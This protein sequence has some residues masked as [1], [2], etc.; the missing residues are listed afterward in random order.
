MRDLL[1]SPA[2]PARYH[3]L[4]RANTHSDRKRE[5]TAQSSA[6][7]AHERPGG[8]I[9][10][11]SAGETILRAPRLDPFI[12]LRN[13]LTGFSGPLARRGPRRGPAV[14]KGAATLSR[15]PQNPAFGGP[16]RPAGSVATLARYPA[17][18]FA[19]RRASPR[20]TNRF[21]AIKRFRK[22]MKGSIAAWRTQA[23]CGTIRMYGLGDFHPFGNFC[24]ASSSDTAGTMMTSSPRRQLTGVATL[25]SAVS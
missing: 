23:G 22:R 8:T 11:R 24:R 25:C 15:G 21:G 2:N 16:S 13:R 6:G 3:G 19:T 20:R 12:L 18:R 14:H 10:R 9:A 4:N 1:P 5:R 17:S 7:I